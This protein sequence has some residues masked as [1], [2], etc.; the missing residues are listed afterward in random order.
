MSFV[1]TSANPLRLICLVTE[2]M[3]LGRH[4]TR[5]ALRSDPEQSE[6]VIITINVQWRLIRA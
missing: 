1:E 4:N 6:V 2:V 3:P 5:E